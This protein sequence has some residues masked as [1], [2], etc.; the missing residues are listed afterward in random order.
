THDLAIGAARLAHVA[1]SLAHPI[2]LLEQV[3]AG[4]HRAATGWREEG[5]EH[6]QGGRLSSPVRPQE[7]EYLAIPDGHVDPG[8][9]LHGPVARL[10]DAPEPVCLDCVGIHP[11]ILANSKARSPIA[12]DDI[13]VPRLARGVSAL[14]HRARAGQLQALL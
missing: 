6:A 14:F 1:D 4:H 3:A 8:D 5:G 12:T 13:D 7:T 9:C 2:L 11:D 10:E